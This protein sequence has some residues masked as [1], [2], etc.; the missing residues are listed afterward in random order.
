MGIAPTC[1]GL[2]SIYR[3]VT[4]YWCPLDLRLMPAD[5]SDKTR[6]GVPSLCAKS[7][8]GLIRLTISG[9]NSRIGFM[10]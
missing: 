5:D 8:S 3:Y 2:P 10:A 7:Q 4:V 1:W 6:A 9:G